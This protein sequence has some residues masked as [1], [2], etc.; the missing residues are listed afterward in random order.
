MGPTLAADRSSHDITIE[1]V[2]LN[3]QGSMN[4]IVLGLVACDVCHIVPVDGGGRLSLN[5]VTV[6]DRN[7]ARLFLGP[8]CTDREVRRYIVGNAPD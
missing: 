7:G 5:M 8:N 4:D 1:R 3:P 6:P 2:V